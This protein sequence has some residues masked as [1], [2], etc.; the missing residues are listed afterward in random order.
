MAERR[1]HQRWSK[2][3]LQKN[4]HGVSWFFCSNLETP[5][6]TTMVLVRTATTRCCWCSDIRWFQWQWCCRRWLLHI[7]L[8]LR[9][10]PHWYRQLVLHFRSTE[11][12]LPAPALRWNPFSSAQ[13]TML[14]WP[15]YTRFHWYYSLHSQ[16][17]ILGKKNNYFFI[18]FI[19]VFII[20]KR[21]FLL[22][23]LNLSYLF[24]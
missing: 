4:N 13:W 14:W 22:S 19:L 18:N 7:N 16:I 12:Q 21:F 10:F 23:F 17:I 2:W 15:P 11:P 6:S 5:N 9:R 8:Q 3:V 1:H 20:Y 24:N